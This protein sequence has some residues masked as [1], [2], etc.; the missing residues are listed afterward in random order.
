MRGGADE[1]GASQSVVDD[2]SK[3]AAAELSLEA[4]TDADPLPSG[5]DAATCS[6]H[7]LYDIYGVNDFFISRLYRLLHPDSIQVPDATSL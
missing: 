1:E 6:M 4:E 7:Y 2:A 3:D 5:T